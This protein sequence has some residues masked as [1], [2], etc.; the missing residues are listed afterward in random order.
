M[1]YALPFLLQLRLFAIQIVYPSSLFD[2][3]W[4]DCVLKNQPA[5][6]VSTAS[7]RSSRA[8]PRPGGR[9]FSLAASDTIVGVALFYFGRVDGVSPTESNGRARDRHSPVEQGLLAGR[10]QPIRTLRESLASAV[11]RGRSANTRDREVRA[12]HDLDLAVEEGQA[13]EDHRPRRRRK[14]DALEAARADHGTDERRRP[15]ARP[16]WGAAEGWYRL[17]PR[18]DRPRTSTSTARCSACRRR[19]YGEESRRSRAS[20]GWRGSSTP[21]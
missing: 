18:A 9:P 13:L 16:G 15:D 19:T 10:V 17:S 1:R 12:L 11:R 6:A 20:A 8:G 5:V 7:G 2:G 14:D 4:P 21:R 3:V